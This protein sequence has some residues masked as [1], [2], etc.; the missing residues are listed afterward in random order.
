MTVGA[1]AGATVFISTI[2]YV[3]REGAT[4]EE[5]GVTKHRRQMATIVRISFIIVEIGLFSRRGREKGVAFNN[6][7]T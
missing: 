1:T 5:V 6:Q 3:V 2:S 7:R 4:G